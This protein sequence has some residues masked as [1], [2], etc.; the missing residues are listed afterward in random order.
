MTAVGSGKHTYTV[1]KD[2]FAL[3]E[4]WQLGWIPAVACDSQDRVYVYS[5]SARPTLG[6][7]SGFVVMF[8]L[9]GDVWYLSFPRDVK[10]FTAQRMFFFSFHV[11]PESLLT[12]SGPR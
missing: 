6:R 5:R 9:F 8:I 2:W 11:V 4:G 10:A 12:L 1:N 3:P 7:R